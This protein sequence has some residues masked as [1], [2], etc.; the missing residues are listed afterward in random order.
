M[1]MKL[2]VAENGIETTGCM[3][4][5]GK[6]APNR[7][8]RSDGSLKNLAVVNSTRGGGL[9]GEKRVRSGKGWG[10]LRYQVPD[11]GKGRKKRK[12]KKKPKEC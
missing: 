12:K 6:V 3:G 11:V 10:P 4:G 1:Q 5:P 9:A 2:G 7:Y 8:G